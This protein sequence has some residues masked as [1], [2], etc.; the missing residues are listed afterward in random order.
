MNNRW[1]QSELN[2]CL[3]NPKPL[4]VGVKIY[5]SFK[6]NSATGVTAKVKIRIGGSYLSR[7]NRQDWVTMDT[8]DT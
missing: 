3:G 1:L 5:D 8:Q 6:G 7:T 4:D 2:E